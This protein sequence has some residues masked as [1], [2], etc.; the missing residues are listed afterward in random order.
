MA[1][2]WRSAVAG[3]GGTAPGG[4]WLC[5]LNER[6]ML[7]PS[8]V[9]PIRGFKSAPLGPAAVPLMGDR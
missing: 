4:T 5:K 3:P 2:D 7:R 6:G 1:G 9:P 8:F